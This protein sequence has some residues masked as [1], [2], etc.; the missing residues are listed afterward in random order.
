MLRRLLALALVVAPTLSRAAAPP[1]VRAAH[2]MVA[3]SSGEAS[4]AGVEI[5][6]AGGNAVDAAVAVSLALVVTHPTAGNLGGGGFMLLR[7]ADGRASAVDYRE[8]APAAASRAMYLDPQSN[9]IPEASTIGYRA[10]GV[11][12]TVAGLQLALEKYGTMSWARV[13]EP[14]IRLAKKGFVVSKALADQL[15]DAA[16][17]LGR[18]PESRRIYLRDGNL[19][20]EGDRFVQPELAR[21]FE[22]LAKAGPRDFY[23]GQIGHALVADVKAHG[24]LITQEDLTAYRAREREV[25]HGT[26]R[27][28]DVLTMPPPSSGGATLLQELNILEGYD[29]A[30][31]GPNCAA[32]DHLE[33]EAMRRAFADR[34]L[35]FWR[36]GLHSGPRRRAHFQGLCRQ[37]ARRDRSRTCDALV[38][39]SHEPSASGRGPPHHPLLGGRFR[40][41][42]GLQHHDAQPAVWFGRD[43]RRR[44]IPL[45]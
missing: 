12:G 10:V 9:L 32:T 43:G 11:P 19:Y 17:Q 23:V 38:G 44:R 37:A 35:Y 30:K 26:Y 5:L 13:S 3:S 40:R 45:E 36:P 33:L 31:S 25:L 21:T 22:R 2:G 41:Q 29:L 7:M 16:P 39:F 1:P 24:G 6:Q 14:A 42:R 34:A 4:Q 15:R 20:Q 28:Y 27:G 18:F 8:V